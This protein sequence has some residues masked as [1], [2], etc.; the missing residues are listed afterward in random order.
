MISAAGVGVGL[1]TLSKTYDEYVMRGNQ[2]R[3]ELFFSLRR[4]LK[5][6]DL[7]RIAD[8]IERAATPESAEDAKQAIEELSKTDPCSATTHSCATSTRP[9][10]TTST[11]TALTGSFSGNSATK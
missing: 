8:L 4:R 11:T 5:E 10:G 1:A 9:F 2:Q 7:S 6:E 3:A